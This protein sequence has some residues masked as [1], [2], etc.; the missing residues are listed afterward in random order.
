MAASGLLKLSRDIQDPSLKKKYFQAAEKILAV[1]THPPYLAGDD[2]AALLTYAARNYCP[3]PAD[4]LTN[5][6]LI[7]GDYYLLE[8]LLAYEKMKEGEMAN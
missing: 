3:D 7:F 6:S 4:R 1:L 2:Q 5:T 8:A